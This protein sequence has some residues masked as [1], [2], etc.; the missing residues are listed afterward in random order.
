MV[1]APRERLPAS[2]AAPAVEQGSSPR[3]ALG[4]G[5]GAG[6]GSPQRALPAAP[7][8][9]LGPTAPTP[10]ASGLRWRQ[11]ALVRPRSGGLSV[12]APWTPTHA[13]AFGRREVSSCRRAGAGLGA[14]P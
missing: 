13:L 14:S 2:V 9:W 12:G 11:A 7:K 5:D 8:A 6:A 10:G 4:A 3:G 1:S